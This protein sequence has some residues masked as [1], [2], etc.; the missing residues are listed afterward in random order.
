MFNLN[1][2]NRFF[3]YPYPTDMRK[4]FYSLSGIVTNL[5]GMNVQDGDAYIFINKSLTGLKILH[6][7]YGGLVIYNMKLVR[8]AFKLPDIDTDDPATSKGIK[9]ADLMMIVQGIS[10]SEVHRCSRWEPKKK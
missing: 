1:D 2:S 5:M 9:W 3:L 4:S 6:A 8:G 10:P 7:E